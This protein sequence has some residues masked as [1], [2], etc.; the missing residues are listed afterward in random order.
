ML[1]ISSNEDELYFPNNAHSM[2]LILFT[3]EMCVRS[4]ICLNS[5]R[6]GNLAKNKPDPNPKFIIQLVITPKICL[7]KIT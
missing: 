7:L 1:L 6:T 3:I 2:G 4:K 5:T